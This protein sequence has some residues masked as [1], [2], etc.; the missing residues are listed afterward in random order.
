MTNVLNNVFLKLCVWL[1]YLQQVPLLQV[2]KLDGSYEVIEQL[3]EVNYFITTPNR[4]KA[5]QVCHVNLLKAYYDRTNKMVQPVLLTD[6]PEL[7]ISSPGDSLPVLDGKEVKGP[8]DGG[9]KGTVKKSL[10]NES[11][12]VMKPTLLN[13]RE[14]KTMWIRSEV[15]I[16]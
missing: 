1:C 12:Y 9:V 11:H 10:R 13:C 15:L 6:P 7:P 8:D 5:T 3:S 4:H 16:L 14:L 2:T